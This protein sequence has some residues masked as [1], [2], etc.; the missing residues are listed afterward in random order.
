[1]EIRSSTPLADPRTTSLAPP[2]ARDSLTPTRFT[3]SRMICAF[4]P[5]RR[6]QSPLCPLSTAMLNTCHFSVPTA[7]TPFLRRNLV[8]LFSMNE[9]REAIAAV[10]LWR[11]R[12]FISC[13][14]CMLLQICLQSWPW[15][16]C[17]PHHCK[18]VAESL[19][20]PFLG[21]LDQT[22]WYFVPR[23]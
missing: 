7:P 6:Q 23:S 16:I 9:S 22:M 13:G 3:A 11:Q 20:Q 17:L 2:N 21:F 15:T 19:E 1:M 12:G 5:I 10:G 18:Y 14:T 4:T 8:D